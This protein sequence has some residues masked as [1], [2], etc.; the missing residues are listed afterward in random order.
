M[1]NIWKL[2]K[3]QTILVTV[4]CYLKKKKWHCNINNIIIV[5]NCYISIEKGENFNG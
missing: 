3:L 1:K 4:K 2:W 5:Y